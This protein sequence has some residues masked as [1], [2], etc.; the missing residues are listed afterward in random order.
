MFRTRLLSGIVLVA[1]VFLLI[2]RGGIVLFAA[3]AVVSL[4]GMREFY[5]ATG[6]SQDS[7]GILSLA[8]YGGALLYEAAVWLGV[9][10]YGLFAVLA[11]LGLLMSVYVF[12]Y[13]RY[14]AGQVMAA[15]F[16]M[17]YVA[18]MLSCVYLTRQLA[19]GFYHVWLIFLC[20]W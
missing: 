20:S 2:F 11:G 5:Q 18:V 19:G 9:Q 15:F 8:G 14:Q 7:V 10:E 3:M 1:A 17:V 12:T 16:G 4:I 13:P 6:V